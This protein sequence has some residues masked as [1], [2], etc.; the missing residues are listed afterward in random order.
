MTQPCK[1]EETY[2]NFAIFKSAVD[3]KTD[4]NQNGVQIIKILSRLLVLFI[5][6]FLISQ[7]IHADLKGPK[8][9]YK[10]HYD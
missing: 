4:I 1:P 9:K 2:C 10:P 3:S 8:L 5:H 7:N 6:L